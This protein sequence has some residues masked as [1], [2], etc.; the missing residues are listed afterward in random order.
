MPATSLMLHNTRKREMQV[1]SERMHF[2]LS[3]VKRAN[4]YKFYK[5]TGPHEHMA[6]ALGHAQQGRVLS[7]SVI[8]FIEN[9]GLT[10][11]LLRLHIN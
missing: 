5:N 8:N 3:A 7:S 11:A 2:Y 10:T 4:I 1:K 9:P 6:R